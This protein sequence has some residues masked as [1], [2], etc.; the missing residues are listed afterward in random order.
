MSSVSDLGL[1]SLIIRVVG[2][3]FFVV[4]LYWQVKLRFSKY[5]D[6]LN[7]LRTLLIGLTLV[8]FLF[9]FLAITNNYI[10]WTN[11]KQSEWLNNFSFFFGAV[12]S[13]VTAIIFWLIYKNRQP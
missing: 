4:V 1:I 8:P 12:A 9:N 3:V 7:G 10:R 2:S 13:T 11:G 5:Q 6:D